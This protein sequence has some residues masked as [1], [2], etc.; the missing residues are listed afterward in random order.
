MD[1]VY[2]FFKLPSYDSIV[3]CLLASSNIKFETKWKENNLVLFSKH[4][5][6]QTFNYLISTDSFLY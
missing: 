1:T 4:C 6:K 2:N 3:L 5:I